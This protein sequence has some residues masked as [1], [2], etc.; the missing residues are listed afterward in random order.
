MTDDL[1]TTYR[2]D[3]RG[4]G[5]STGDG[6]HTLA[7]NVADL[8]GLRERWGLERF[9]VAGHSWGADLALH[10]AL[11]YPHRARSLIYLSGC[12]IDPVFREQYRAERARRYGP[13]GVRARK[14][15][16]A[17]W[18][19]EGTLEAERRYCEV[20]WS[21]DY[22]DPATARERARHMFVED[23]R[24]NRAVNAE[25][26]ADAR[27]E[28]FHAS[29]PARLRSMQAPSIVI[30]GSADPRPALAAEQ[31]AELLPHAE[32]KVVEGAGH[33]PWVEEPTIFQNVLRQYILRLTTCSTQAS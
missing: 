28:M 13:E 30:H 33:C 1:V 2:Y 21:T 10:Y 29:M 24:V 16:E 19:A 7:R 5:R 23:L 22:A 17:R 8:E 3:Q 9:I 15:L 31:V 4:C 12:G 20:Q 18:L 32:F 26:A 11:T 6:P 14:E 25:L 27:N